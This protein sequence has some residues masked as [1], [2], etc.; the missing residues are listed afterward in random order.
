MGLNKLRKEK[1]VCMIRNIFMDNFGNQR[2][3]RGEI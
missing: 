2:K 3:N 1:N